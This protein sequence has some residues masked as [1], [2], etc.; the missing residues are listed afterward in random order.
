MFP[1]ATASD[2]VCH[3]YSPVDVDQPPAVFNIPPVR[4]FS[5]YFKN[6]DFNNSPQLW[7]H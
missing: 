5:H 3:L 7:G 1:T 4:E 6:V 2:D